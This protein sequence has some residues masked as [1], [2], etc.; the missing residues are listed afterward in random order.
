MPDIQIEKTNQLKPLPDF[1]QVGF[2]KYFTD[3]MFCSDYKKG[4]WQN[5]RIVPYA[6]IAL[7]PAASVLHYGQALFEGMK[8]FY[9][10]DGQIALFRPK[11]NWER[12]VHGADRLCMKAPPWEV[13][14]AGLKE[15]VKLEKRWIPRQ[16]GMSLYIR[17]TLIATEAFL[18]VK[19]SE[20]YL[21]FIILSPAAN[22]YKEGLSPLSIWIEEDHVR[23]APGGLGSTKAA[24]NYASSL[25]AAKKARDQ[26]HAQV[27]WLDVTKKYIEEVGTMNVFFRLKE[28]GVDKVITPALDGTILAGNTRSCVIDLLKANRVPCD[29]RK[30]SLQE[31]MDHQSK[32]TLLEVFGTGTAA[33]ISSVG[34]LVMREKTLKI[35][36]GKIGSLSQS[37]YDQLTSIQHGESSDQ[38]NWLEKIT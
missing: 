8:A 24:A 5:H 10:K 23:A 6:P 32:G 11:Y 38:F 21:F 33:L 18:G 22:Y 13:M 37:L 20:E 27:L 2:G 25:F 1:S 36:D 30:V 15:L 14:E 12:M 3:Y 19:P 29:E 34:Q 16:R 7:D 26:G 35:Q 9:Q 4:Q 17:P 31:L 28:N